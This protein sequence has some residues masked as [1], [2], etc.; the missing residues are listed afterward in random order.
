MEKDYEKGFKLSIMNAEM[1]PENKKVQK[2]LGREYWYRFM[3][4]EAQAKFKGLAGEALRK[5]QNDFYTERRKKLKE[6][7]AEK[8]WT[9]WQ[10]YWNRKKNAPSPDPESKPGSSVNL[11]TTSLVE[12]TDLD[13]FGGWKAMWFPWPH[14]ESDGR[15]LYI[16]GYGQ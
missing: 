4:D 3:L 2:I 7:F 5:A 9:L 8:Q 6:V 13:R 10:S 16:F 1:Y 14:I 11:S 12:S 15:L